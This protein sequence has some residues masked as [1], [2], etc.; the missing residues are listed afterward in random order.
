MQL[1]ALLWVGFLVMAAGGFWAAGLEAFA[2][3]NGSSETRIVGQRCKLHACKMYGQA[4]HLLNTLFEGRT[5]CW[6]AP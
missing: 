4:A 2:I 3:A 6:R 5:Q 1:H